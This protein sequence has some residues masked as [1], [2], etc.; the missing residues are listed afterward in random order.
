[1][2]L[3]A[4][5]NSGINRAAEMS[6]ELGNRALD[7]YMQQYEAQAPL[8]QAAADRAGLVSDA[9]LEAMRTATDQAR[10]ADAYQDRVFR[11]VEERIASDALGYDTEARREQAAGRAV[12]DVASQFANQRAALTQQLAR[13]GFSPLS[14]RAIALQSQ[15]AGDEALAKAAAAAAARDKVETVG[16]AM[17]ADAANL[18]RG[19]ASSQATQAGLALSSGNSSVNNAQVP[20]GLAQQGTQLV[21]QGFQTAMQGQNTAG[22]LYSQAAQLSQTNDAGLF[23]AL[24]QVGGAAIMTYSDEEMKEGIKPAKGEIA[25]KAV[26]KMPVKQWRY[27]KDSAANDGGEEHV[28]P[29]AQSVRAALGDRAA[30]GGK[31]VDLISLAGTALAAV[32]ELD[33]RVISLERRIKLAA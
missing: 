11:P 27:R 9:Q 17:R 12:T 13:T 33:D 24:G 1:M 8:R 25:L 31:Q 18:G 16:R 15:M 5:D 22:N 23:G 30:P 29:M 6:A 4:P 21:G 14:G 3:D 7:W 2:C 32:K 26:R 20:V 19:I 28:G 10:R